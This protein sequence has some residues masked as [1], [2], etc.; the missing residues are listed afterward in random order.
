MS[1]N[2]D[3]IDIRSGA[4]DDFNFVGNLTIPSDVTGIGAEAFARNDGFQGGLT[5]P[6]QTLAIG[7]FA[8]SGCGG[9]SSLSFQN[10][11]FSKLNDIGTGAFRDY[12]KWSFPR[13]QRFFGQVDN[14]R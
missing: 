10:Y 2:S 14:T 11:E 13:V 4:F 9:F 8:F 7:N 3:L 12:T 5:I 1:L 6:F